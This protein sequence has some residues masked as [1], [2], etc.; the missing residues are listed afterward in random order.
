MSKIIITGVSGFIGNKLLNH[1]ELKNPRLILRDN[2]GFE[3]YDCFV[4]DSLSSETTFSGA[5]DNVI[6]VIHLAGLAHSNCYSF[7]DYMTVNFDG[8]IKLAIEAAKS[9]VKRFVYVST[10]L[11]DA[12]QSGFSKKLKAYVYSK[13]MSEHKL[14]EICR[15]YNME[16][17]VVRPVLVYG[18]KAPANF[19]KLVNLVKKFPVVPFGMIDNKRD[20]ISVD[21]LCDLLMLCCSNKN[22]PG[23]IIN[24][25]DG[26]PI[27]T[28]K[29]IDEISYGLNKNI[30]NLK[31]PPNILRILLKVIGQSKISESLLDD[32]LI[33]DNNAQSLLG[34][35]P[36]F[37]MQYTLSM[38]KDTKND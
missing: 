11:I 7:S 30:L 25:T 23:K 28:T 37:T 4:I 24:A 9:G 32:L 29:L 3:Q 26:C 2:Y 18:P 16:L 34:W 22:A 5:F 21:N 33:T 19:G 1:P 6:S 13:S 12:D 10:S 36:P 15:K 20:L 17:V 31:V 27:S 35:S 8:T 14:F 38:L